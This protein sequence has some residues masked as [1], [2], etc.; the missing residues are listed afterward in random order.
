MPG[1]IM[2]F[3]PDLTCIY[4]NDNTLDSTSIAEHIELLL[5]Q[6]HQ[7]V[8]VK[9]TTLQIPIGNK[10]HYY[11]TQVIPERISGKGEQYYLV[12]CQDI[13]N[14][15]VAEQELQALNTTRDKLFSIIAHDL[16]NP[17]TSLLSYSEIIAKNANNLEKEK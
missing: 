10:I 3:G 6:A 14:L 7:D 5:L 12:I 2:R 17:F 8:E 9:Q 11:A 15:K 4:T 13:T 1:L 16:R